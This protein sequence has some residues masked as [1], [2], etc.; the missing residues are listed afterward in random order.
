MPVE[1]NVDLSGIKV[2]YETTFLSV[3]GQNEQ[4]YQ[5]TVR[6]FENYIADNGGEF[7]NIEHWGQKRLEYPIE[8]HNNAYYTYMEYHA[9]GTIVAPLEQEFRYDERVIRYL[10]VKVGKHHAAFNKKRREQGFGKKEKKEN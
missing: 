5:D 1:I 2:Q 9:P 7:I 6:K 8:R 10:T 4:E 3:P